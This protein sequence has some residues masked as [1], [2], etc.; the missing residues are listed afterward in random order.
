MICDECGKNPAVFSVTITS[1]GDTSNRHLCGDCMKKMEATFTQGNI[2]GFLSSILGMLGAAQKQ[3]T[4]TVCSHCGLSYSEFERTGRLGCA[5]CYQDFQ[6]E[7]KP[8]LQRIHGSSQHVGRT[9][10][11]YKA[12]DDQKTTEQPV[13]AEAPA[14]TPEELNAKR[15][16]EL[17]QKMDE[18]VAVENFEAA[19]QYRDEIRALSQEAGEPSCS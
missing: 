14:P 6:K 12:A 8:M 2:H 4:Q 15:I 18:A 19:A 13:A 5:Q 17:R 3:E 7:L 10:A 16:E 9:P 11:G 1:G